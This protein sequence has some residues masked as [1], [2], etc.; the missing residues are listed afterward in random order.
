MERLFVAAK[1]VSPLWFR[2]RLLTSGLAGSPALRAP[3]DARATDVGGWWRRVRVTE[4]PP[5][6]PAS[7]EH[8]VDLDLTRGALQAATASVVRVVP[9]FSICSNGPCGTGLENR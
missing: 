4:E 1:P 7:G 8:A 9:V 2:V 5:A 3:H 6:S